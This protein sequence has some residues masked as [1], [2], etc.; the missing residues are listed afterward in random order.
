MGMSVKSRE[1]PVRGVFKFLTPH[2]SLDMLGF[3]DAQT[4]RSLNG[5]IVGTTADIQIDKE[6]TM[7]LDTADAD[8]MFGGNSAPQRDH[9]L[10]PAAVQFFTPF[11]LLQIG[12]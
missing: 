11:V 10:R 2:A 12:R 9:F 3:I 4:F 8:S 1:V 6:E 5:M 7:L